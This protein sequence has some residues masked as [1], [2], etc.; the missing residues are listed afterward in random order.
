MRESYRKEHGTTFAWGTSI[1]K[2]Y[3]LNTDTEIVYNLDKLCVPLHDDVY[4]IGLTFGILYLK[5]EIKLI[6]IDR[7]GENMDMEIKDKMHEDIENTV[8]NYIVNGKKGFTLQGV[9]NGH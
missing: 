6:Y 1:Q 9:I 2:I 7:Y 5:N 3:L 4:E 8:Y